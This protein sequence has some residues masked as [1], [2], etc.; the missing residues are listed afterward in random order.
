MTS[1]VTSAVKCRRISRG[2]L[3]EL[4]LLRDDHRCRVFALKSKLLYINF[5][6]NKAQTII[7]GQGAFSSQIELHVR[8]GR[9]HKAQSRPLQPSLQAQRQ[10][11]GQCTSEMTQRPASIKTKR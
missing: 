5:N 8:H 1:T 2:W 4:A 6:H 7:E 11:I 3:R 9:R 10:P